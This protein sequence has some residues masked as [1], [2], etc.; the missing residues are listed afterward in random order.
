MEEGSASDTPAAL[1]IDMSRE[2]AADILQKLSIGLEPAPEN[3]DINHHDSLKKEGPDVD[4]SDSENEDE[5]P[6]LTLS[7]QDSSDEEAM[8]KLEDVETSMDVTDI[9]G[10]ADNT[11]TT[12]TVSPTSGSC[13]KPKLLISEEKKKIIDFECSICKITIGGVKTYKGKV[14]F[15]IHLL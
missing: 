2:T 10:H 12:V 5:C 14:S 1:E 4:N 7:D 15:I 8:M 3:S 6:N 9:S 11:V 13:D